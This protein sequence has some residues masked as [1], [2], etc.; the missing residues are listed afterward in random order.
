M[1][2]L[3]AGDPKL[4]EVLCVA[5]DSRR[6][7]TRAPLP[8]DDAP[9]KPASV[10]L[11]SAEDDVARTIV[12][13]LKAAGADLSRVHILESIILPRDDSGNRDAIR[14]ADRATPYPACV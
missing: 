2:T 12:P 6:G 7:L 9:E 8:G 14:P 10:I 1:L 13:R 11:M 5:G 4:G 3:F